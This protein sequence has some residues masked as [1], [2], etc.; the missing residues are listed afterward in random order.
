MEANKILLEKKYARIIS[1]IAMMKNIPREEAM[2]MFYESE[3]SQIMNEGV[4]DLHCH[5]DRYLAEEVLI[6]MELRGQELQMRLE[7]Q[8]KQKDSM[9]RRLEMYNTLLRKYAQGENTHECS[10]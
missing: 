9:A 5:G 3:T 6:E 4:A 1:Y 8:E 7:L 10:E 2:R